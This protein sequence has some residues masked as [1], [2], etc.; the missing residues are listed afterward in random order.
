MEFD[1][2][3]LLEEVTHLVEAGEWRIGICRLMHIRNAV[4]SIGLVI[5]LGGAFSLMTFLR[6]FLFGLKIVLPEHSPGATSD[7]SIMLV[8]APRCCGHNVR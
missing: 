2:W 5:G 7:E 3:R 8:S 1:F 4:G 6:A